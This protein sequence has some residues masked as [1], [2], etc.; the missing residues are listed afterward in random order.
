[1]GKLVKLGNHQMELNQV[2]FHLLTLSTLKI[3]LKDAHPQILKNRKNIDAH[4]CVF[5]TNAWTGRSLIVV[6]V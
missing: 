5:H 2:G 1:M 4:K 6:N 3:N